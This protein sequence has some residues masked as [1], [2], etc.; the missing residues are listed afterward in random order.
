MISDAV[1]FE[2]DDEEVED[3]ANVARDAE[4]SEIIDLTSPDTKI[5]PL[6]INYVNDELAYDQPIMTN[7][8]QDVINVADEDSDEECVMLNC[9]NPQRKK[10]TKRRLHTVCEWSS[11]SRD[12]MIKHLGKGVT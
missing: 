5:N 7:M 6:S 12:K 1:N 4:P 9:D 8:D 10:G 2:V 3:D 11:S